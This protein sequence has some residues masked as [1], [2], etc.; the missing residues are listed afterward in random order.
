MHLLGKEM[1]A[2]AVLPNRREV[3]LVW[4]KDWDFNWQFTYAFREPIKLP[5]GTWIHINATYDNSSNNPR[6][7]NNPPKEVRWGEQTTDE[8]FLLVGMFAPGH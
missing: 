3:P 1:K 5:S 2:W 8:M 4:V 7:P 6:N